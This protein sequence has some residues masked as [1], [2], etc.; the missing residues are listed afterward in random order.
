MQPEE[1]GPTLF[2][3]MYADQVADSGGSLWDEGQYQLRH[4]ASTFLLDSKCQ[5]PESQNRRLYYFPGE[6]E[7]SIY[8]LTF[9]LL[10]Y[11]RI[12]LALLVSKSLVDQVL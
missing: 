9:N 5:G 8:L 6:K 4:D 7:S 10:V 2:A 3:S 11:I 1:I 12:I